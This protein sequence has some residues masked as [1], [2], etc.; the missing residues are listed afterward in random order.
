MM[1]MLL[2]RSL[3]LLLL[4]SCLSEPVESRTLNLNSCSVSVHT[5]ELR[6]HYTDIR[7]NAIEG[8]SE[9]GV[10]LLNKS[11]MKQVQDGQKCCLLRLVLR[12]YVERVFSNYASSQ[13][14][15]QRH[16]SA[17]ANSF[18]S[19]RREIHKCHCQCVEDTQRKID[20]VHAEF[21]KLEISQAAKKA[22]G[23]LDTVLEWMEGLV[24]KTRA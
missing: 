5:T 12:F 24:L 3:C 23:E 21:I 15:Q 11:L 13:P 1:K 4:L 17:L 2:A 7:S 20:T 19:I 10:R 22:V 8:D 16:T 6:T 14:Q 18:V 9:I